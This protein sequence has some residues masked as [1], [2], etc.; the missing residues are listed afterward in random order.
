MRRPQTAPAVINRRRV[1]T[2][3]IRSW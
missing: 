1:F 2:D 3:E